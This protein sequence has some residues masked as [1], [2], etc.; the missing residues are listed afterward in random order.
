MTKTKSLSDLTKTFS[1]KI[2]DNPDYVSRVNDA[3]ENYFKI[4]AMSPIEQPIYSAVIDSIGIPVRFEPFLEAFGA[5]VGIS[6]RNID[7]FHIS[8]EHI[9]M[10]SMFYEILKSP[11]AYGVKYPKYEMVFVYAH[12][13]FH[14]FFRHLNK[15]K[16]LAR[17]FPL[18]HVVYNIVFDIF[19]NTLLK[20][21]PTLTSKTGNDLMNLQMFRNGMRYYENVDELKQNLSRSLEILEEIGVKSSANELSSLF[22]MGKE[23]VEKLSD[24]E[25][26]ELFYG[27][28]K[29][30]L[31]PWQEL[32]NEAMDEVAGQNQGQMQG[33]GSPSPDGEGDGEA[34]G[35]SSAEDGAEGEGSSG[36]K[37]SQTGAGT[38]PNGSGGSPGEDGEGEGS[39]NS[40][41]Q[42]SESGE[43]KDDRTKIIEALNKKIKERGKT[44]PKFADAAKKFVANFSALPSPSA[45]YT[46]EVGLE[47]GV[48]T[49]KEI[50]EAVRGRSAA[51]EIISNLSEKAAGTLPG[52]VRQFADVKP[53]RPS[54]L[55]QLQS[56]GNRHI[57]E[58]RKTFSPPNK[59]HSRP[60][61][62]IPSKV[63]TALDIAFI[64][65]TSG[66]M[67]EDEINPVL[68]QISAV[69]RNAPTS[70][71][72]HVLFNDAGVQHEVI[73]GKGNAKLRKILAAGVQGGGGSVFDDVFQ[74][75]AIRQVDAIIFLSDFY[76]YINDELRVTK[77]LVCLYTEQYNDRVLKEVM[78]R[79]RHSIALPVGRLD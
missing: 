3:V 27:Q 39:G 51:G 76:I 55:S 61:L 14:A 68:G 22:I 37:G 59:K 54:Y 50:A 43:P 74:H 12:E 58:T 23:V 69:L 62:L 36:G 71:K 44:D 7:D 13:L 11:S 63:G 31:D 29:D 21:N 8:G 53:K 33:S 6:P 1:E 78:D 15:Q 42:E 30:F 28:H 48:M 40:E 17:E 24:N 25:L 79:A 65:D 66:S 64:I 18:P 4:H 41:G 70:S 2:K 72:V 52:W 26:A 57:G 9:V 5:Y 32:M 35:E 20:Y 46:L 16:I 56:F 49:P 10:S 45:Q 47:G 19:I 38:S 77:P 73:R 60:N 67:S 34:G 75:P